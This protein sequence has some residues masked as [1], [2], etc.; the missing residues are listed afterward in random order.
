M[1]FSVDIDGEDQKEVNVDLKYN[2]YFVTA[3]PCISSQH[4][5]VLKSQSSPPSPQYSPGSLK[6]FTAG[7]LLHKAF[8]YTTVPL[9]SLLHSQHQAFD[10]L[11]T[12]PTSPTSA[13]HSSMHTTNS[14]IPRVLVI[15]CAD[16]T[17]AA[18]PIRPATSPRLGATRQDVYGSD[19][20]ILA[21]A[22]CAERG[23]NAVISRRGRGCLSCAIREAG[24]LGW[25][26]VVRLG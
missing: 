13:V 26:V 14:T 16:N 15:D 6:N 22:V 21:R 17:A 5:E 25:R 23:W 4:S 19:L 11:L 7:H 18:F 3:F 2:I 1:R 8:T 10:A 24:A 12:P 20:E 9:F